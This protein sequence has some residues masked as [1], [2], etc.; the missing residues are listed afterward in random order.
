MLT[1]HPLEVLAVR[2]EAEDAIALTLRVPEPLRASFR[3][4]AGQHV[5]LRVRAGGEELRRTYSIVSA[6]GD[7]A[8]RLDIRVHGEGR[9][10]RHLARAVRAGDVLEVMTPGGSFAARHPEPGR[11]YVAFAA[12][13]GITPVY[14]L[15]AEL[16]ATLEG[17]RVL[18]FYGNRSTA[19]TMLLEELMALKDRYPER[20]ALHFIMSREPQESALFNG[21]IDAEKVR[22]V[23]GR[24]F[25]PAG[26]ADFLICGPGTMID[27]V[28]RALR[29]LGVDPARIH[30]EH[31]TLDTVAQPARPGQAGGARRGR[32]AGITEVAVVMDGRR[33]SFTMRTGEETILDAAARAGIELPYS[34]RAGVCSTCRTRLTRGEVE[35]IQNY[36]L[37]DAELEEGFILACQ[38]Q[39]KTP[40]IEIDYDER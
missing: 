10:S 4:H 23:A 39:A 19:R 36:A 8:L 1:F 37:E 11:T 34:C 32:E 31:F 28:T 7:P 13:C 38:S 25:D 5:V 3:H 40:E 35:M 26:V 16:L 17:S 29:E 15:V 30:A 12:G 18:L 27:D 9:V 2:P 33:R 21:R 6:P 24:L 14:A 20:L 22:A